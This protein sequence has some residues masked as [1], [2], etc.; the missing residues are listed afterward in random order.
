MIGSSF[1][2][3]LDPVTLRDPVICFAH[4]A[5]QFSR[6]FLLQKTG[7]KHFEVR[8][9][10]DLESRI[11]DIDVL[12]VSGLWKNSL[13][14]KANRLRLVQSISAG[15]DQYDVNL[16]KELNVR[17]A[18]GRGVNAQA[19]SEHALG[20]M[21]SLS[22]QLYLFRDFQK[23]KFWRPMVGDIKKREGELSG[24]I[25]LIVGLGVIGQRIAQL[26]KA[27][28]MHVIAI[29]ENVSKG[30]LGA[31]EVHSPEKLSMLLP[32]IDLLILSCPLTDKTRGLIDWKE[33]QLMKSSA[34]LINVSRGAVINEQALYKALK[35]REIKAAAAD[36]TS[37]EPLSK[38]SPLWDLNNFILTPHSGG[39]TQCYEQNVIDVMLENLSRLQRGETNLLNQIV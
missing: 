36:V 28:D 18:S 37:D 6:V 12:V 19:V 25:L 13:L 1:V 30:N 26:A 33:L 16:F 5:Y 21:L 9:F 23:K 14:E 7:I 3:I 17:L 29:R 24:K 2:N 22:R 31:D 32:K 11:N 35:D 10:F 27:F 39:E 38:R 4:I 15:I 8:S 20:L 34:F